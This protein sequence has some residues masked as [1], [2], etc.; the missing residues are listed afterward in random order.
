MWLCVICILSAAQ[1]IVPLGDNEVIWT[2]NFKLLVHREVS[3]GVQGGVFL[4]LRGPEAEPHQEAHQGK[5]GQPQ[6]PVDAGPQRGQRFTHLRPG[7]AVEQQR[8]AHHDAHRHTGD[9]HWNDVD[10]NVNAQYFHR[11]S[12]CNYCKY[13]ESCKE[14]TQPIVP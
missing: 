4:P 7:G 1:Q 6:V 12:Y 13:M 2:L 11:C 3:W 5:H 9:G 8:G 10:P 14:R